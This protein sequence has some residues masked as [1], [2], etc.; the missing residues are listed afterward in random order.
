M[1]KWQSGIEVLGRNAVR[2]ESDIFVSQKS[3]HVV[4]KGVENGI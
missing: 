4:N 2:F 3:D 1:V